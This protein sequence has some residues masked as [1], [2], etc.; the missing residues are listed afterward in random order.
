MSGFVVIVLAISL[1]IAVVLLVW[2]YSN[3]LTRPLVQKYWWQLVLLLLLLL[4][5]LFIF[6]KKTKRFKEELKE[7][8]EGGQKLQEESLSGVESLIRSTREKIAVSDAIYS[9][10][11]IK[12]AKAHGDALH[13]IRMAQ[14]IPDDRERLKALIALKGKK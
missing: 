3:P 1:L 13:E 14:D 11:K 7:G 8:R 6:S 10:Q 12:G 2:L 9:V 5:L 4:V